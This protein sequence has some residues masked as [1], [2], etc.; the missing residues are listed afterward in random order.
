MSLRSSGRHPAT[1]LS[2]AI[3]LAVLLAPGAL[4]DVCDL[5]S[6]VMPGCARFDPS[7]ALSFDVQ[8]ICSDGRPLAGN[9]VRMVFGNPACTGLV[10]KSNTAAKRLRK[11][12]LLMREVCLG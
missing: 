8:L 5:D 9:A 3:S 10:A 12:V 4:A 1:L 11:L 7:G 6:S 2:Y